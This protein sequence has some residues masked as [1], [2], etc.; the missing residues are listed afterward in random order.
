[1]SNRLAVVTTTINAPHAIKLLHAHALFNMQVGFFVAGDLKTPEQE[2]ADVVKQCG[3]NAFYLSVETQKKLNY[4]CSDL[5]GWGCIQ[6]RNIATLEAL[7]WGADVLVFWD[8]D[9]LPID[10]LYFNNFRDIL[11]TPFNGLEATS[12]SGW[13][14]VGTLL[15]PTASHRGFPHEKACPPIITHVV[16]AKV[17][18]AAGMCLLDPD[19]S[20]V[21]RIA[22][23]PIVHQV[24]RLLDGGIAV[25]PKKTRTVWNSQNSAFVRE[26][27]PAF[28]MVPQF[29]RYDDILCSIIVQKVMSGHV[30]FGNPYV[31]QQRNVHNLVKDLEAEI[32]GMKHI[33]NFTECVQGTLFAGFSVADKVHSVYAHLSGWLDLP[34]GVNRLADAWLEDVESVL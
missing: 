11:S 7:K 14:D 22:R 26:L 18:V 15:D 13:F 5:I 24:S 33:L 32:W 19:I 21:T 1:M 16:G 10:H 29:S 17:Q 20:A 31:A 9:N 4:R 27:A 8:D 6:R 3:A 25:D 2:C 28:L 30:H 23:A 12:E 34:Q